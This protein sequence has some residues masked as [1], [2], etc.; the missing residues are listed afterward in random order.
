MIDFLRRLIGFFEQYNIQYMLSG[1]VA[2]SIYVLPRSTKDFDFIVHLKPTDAV[3]LLDYFKE[4]YYCNEDSVKAAIRSGG[5]FNVI[6]YQS[7]YKADMIVLRKEPFRQ[8]EFKR[9]KEVAFM[10]MKIH[11]VSAEDLLISKIIWIQELQSD[12]QKTDIKELGKM[13]GLDRTY[14]NYWI[15]SLKLNTFGLINL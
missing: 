15:S 1:S 12:I 13:T 10:N 3:T 5:M 6:D 7:G 4:G 11:I 8:E 2:M 9:R 14:I